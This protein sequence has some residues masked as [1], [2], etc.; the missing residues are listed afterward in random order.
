MRVIAS[1]LESGSKWE[2]LSSCLLTEQH[3][4]DYLAARPVHGAKLPKAPRR[5]SVYSAPAPWS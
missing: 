1:E 5:P 3:M 2:D 4:R